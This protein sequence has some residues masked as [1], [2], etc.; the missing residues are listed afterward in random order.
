VD[1]TFRALSDPNNAAHRQPWFFAPS[2][3]G[4]SPVLCMQFSL[5]P[6]FKRFHSLG[7]VPGNVGWTR[8]FALGLPLFEWWLLRNDDNKG[9]LP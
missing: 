5:L 3:H 9:F 7:A 8:C 6:A 4:R 1:F 2:T